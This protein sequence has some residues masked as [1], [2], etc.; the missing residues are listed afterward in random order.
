MHSYGYARVLRIS[1]CRVIQHII[2][3]AQKDTRKFHTKKE[4]EMQECV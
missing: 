1:S 3:A 4:C 2:K